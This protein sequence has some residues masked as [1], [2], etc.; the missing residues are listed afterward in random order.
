MKGYTQA[1]GKDYH[2]MFALVAKMNTIEFFYLWLS[3]KTGFY[4]NLM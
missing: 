4:I 2:K 3:S 1:Y